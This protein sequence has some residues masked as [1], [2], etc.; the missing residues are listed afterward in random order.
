MGVFD[1]HGQPVKTDSLN[2]VYSNRP[3]GRVFKAI[4]QVE[5]YLEPV[6]AEAGPAPFQRQ[7]EAYTKRSEI[8]QLIQLRAAGKT[9]DEISS[10][11]KM[12]KSTIS[13]HLNRHK[14]HNEAK[15]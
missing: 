12:A 10:Q 9:I 15:A 1:C 8:D 11:M 14:A 5:E 2:D 3:F 6:F 13:R 7:A 4:K